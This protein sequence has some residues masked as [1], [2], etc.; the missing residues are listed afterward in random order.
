MNV[1]TPAVNAFRIYADGTESGSTALAAENT[2]YT[3]DLSDRLILHV[4]YRIQETAGADGAAS[5][6]Y[7]LEYSRNG[8]AYTTV[9]GGTYVSN[10]ST[11]AL[12]DGAATTNR[13]TG[14][15]DGT[16]SFVAGVQEEGNGAFTHLLTASNFTEHV[17][18]VILLWETLADGDTLDFR[19]TL[20]GG[21]PGITN[22]VTP[23]ITVN[24]FTPNLNAFRF[25]EDGTETGASPIG[26]EDADINRVVSSNSQVQ[27]RV[28]LDEVG[29]ASGLSTDD[30]LIRFSHNSG[31]WTTPT[32]VTSVVQMDS[33][34]A[35]T[36]NAA[37]T[38]R[39]TDGISD[40]GTGSFV[41]GKQQS[42][43]ASALNLQLTSGNFME[44]VYGLLLISAD[45]TNG[46]TLD[47]KIAAV[48]NVAVELG[49]TATPR[50]TIAGSVT[51]V[52]TGQAS[53]LATGSGSVS[54]DVSFLGTGLSSTLATGT[55][56]IS[57]PISN[58]TLTGTGLASALATGSGSVSGDVSF[59]GTGLASTLAYGTGTATGTVTYDG[60]GQSSTLA[61]GSGSIGGTTPSITLNGTGL[62]STA[63]FGSGSLDNIISFVGTGLD[64]T[65]APGSGSL[66]STVIFVGTGRATDN[67]FGT[68]E[69]SGPGGGGG[70]V[71]NR[72]RARFSG[73]LKW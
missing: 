5:D 43:S 38:N 50:I 29:G 67:V 65:L 31:A 55:G 20:N 71:E 23:R 45:L 48:K 32:G 18:A 7:A 17:W 40:P 10:S 4:R 63:T 35:L 27:L 49:G 69:I 2:N 47:F 51:L 56:S 44:L 26:A 41:A 19:V 25:Y 62:A 70:G 16:G 33:S 1:F 13:A 39:A 60:A 24:R 3:A 42:T 21:T 54:G 6:A 36:N 28:R 73:G 72:S 58:V 8:G 22:S 14:L 12:T 53:T 30:Y 64:S 66:S 68:G 34:S 15:T 61:F 11:S 37:T 52:G 9:N 59:V 46:D 57:E